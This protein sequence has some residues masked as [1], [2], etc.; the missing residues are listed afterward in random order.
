MSDATLTIDSLHAVQ[1]VIAEAGVDGWLLF[2]FRGINPIALGV[3]GLAK[4]GTRRIA[5][6]IPANGTPVALSHAI[7]QAAWAHWPASWPRT[8]YATWQDFER[9]IATHVAGRRVAMEYSARDAIP[10]IDRVP[11]GVVDLVREAGATIESSSAIVTRLYAVWT[12]AQTAA[13]ERAA[14]LVAGIAHEAAVRAGAAADAATPLT[15]F[16]LVQWIAER[17]AHAGLVTGSLPHVAAGVN[18]A[19]PHYTP[20]AESSAPIVRDQLLLIDLWAREPEGI[21]ADQTWMASLGAPSSRALEVWTAVRDARDAAA[22]FLRERLWTGVPVRGAEADD[23]A[24][25]VLR[26]RALSDWFTHRTGHSIDAR[27]LHGAGPHLDGLETRDDRLLLP[28]VGFSIEPGVYIPGEIGVR[29]EVNAY[30]GVDGLVVTPRA[31]QRDLW[32][33]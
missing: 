29:S 31:P 13:H 27:E 32:I 3:L 8:V 20:S 2:D 6:W 1:T 30:V 17:F 4:P 22:H 11:A 12:P 28:G 21:Y 26:E 25:G 18:A 16:A 9:F 7:E 15:E 14:E 10:Y 23:V 5:A 24:R 19:D 33:V